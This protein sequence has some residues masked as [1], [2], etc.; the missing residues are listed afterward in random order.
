MPKFHYIALDQNG[1]E[2]AGVIDAASDADA[3]NQLRQSQLYPTQVVQEGKG[4]VA[5]IK[6]KSRSGGKTKGKAAAGGNPATL[7]VKGKT[8]MIF[9]RQLATLI[10]SG[11]PLLRGLTVLGR[12]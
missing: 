1:Q 2:T 12:Q 5:A 11:L 9:T 3:I 6:K 10:D 7:K 4:D 8:L